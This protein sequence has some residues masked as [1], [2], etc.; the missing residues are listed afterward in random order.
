[1]SIYEDSFQVKKPVAIHAVAKEERAKNCSAAQVFNAMKG[2]GTPNGSEQLEL[3]GGGSLTRQDIENATRGIRSDLR[4]ILPST[5]FVKDVA[6]AEVIL[7]E[8]GWLYRQYN[9]T[10]TKGEKR[11]GLAFGHPE[12]PEILKRRGHL[13]LFDSTHRLN[14]W[15]HNMFSFLVRE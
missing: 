10:D 2:V 14:R 9:V 4:S 3:A 11:W 6:E 12:R 1:M 15:N 8:N 13:T 5:G 7:D